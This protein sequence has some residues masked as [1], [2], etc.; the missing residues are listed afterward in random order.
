MCIRCS[1][2]EQ[3]DEQNEQSEQMDDFNLDLTDV[4]KFHGLKGVIK[5]GSSQKSYSFFESYAI[6]YRGQVDART[7]AKKARKNVTR[8]HWRS[9]RHQ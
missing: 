1:V 7:S 5:E 6:P 3:K 2:R 4:R 8:A 9:F